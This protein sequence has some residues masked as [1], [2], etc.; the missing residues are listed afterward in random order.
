MSDL[1]KYINRRKKHDKSF[2]I[3]FDLGYEN[4]KLGAILK[5]ARIEKGFT[6]E[7]LDDKIKT[8]KTA[9]SRLENHA[10]DMKI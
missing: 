9:I 3:N 7:V 1:K 5:E 8:K 6:Q 2:A 4:F 10:E